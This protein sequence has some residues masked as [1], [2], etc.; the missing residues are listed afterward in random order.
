MSCCLSFP[1]QRN[2]EEGT[3]KDLLIANKWKD[4]LTGHDKLL[5]NLFDRSRIWGDYGPLTG[6]KTWKASVCRQ[7]TFSIIQLL[8]QLHNKNLHVRH[9]SV[10]NI[11][12]VSSAYQI[13]GTDILLNGLSIRISGIA[14]DIA[15]IGVS[16]LGF[17]TLYIVS[18]HISRA[19][20]L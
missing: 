2:Y 5:K 7:Y 15:V 1:D 17:L 16:L 10:R 11:S 19:A 8:R 4:S 12:I 14:V 3:S 6:I 20:I 18:L 13:V 9:H